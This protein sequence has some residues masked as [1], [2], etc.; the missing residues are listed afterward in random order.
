MT[1][2]VASTPG[3]MF[4]AKNDRTL[5]YRVWTGSAWNAEQS[6]ST[7]GSAAGDNIRHIRAERSDDG[8]RIAIF[9]KTWDGTNQEWWG[10]VYRVAADDFVN[11]EILGASYASADNN[12]LITG[13]IGA[14]S[15]GEF[16]VIRNNNGSAGTLAFSWD[17]TGG[18][19][20]EGSGPGSTVGEVDVMNG[21]QLARREGADNLLLVTFD[22]TDHG[23]NTYGDVGTSYYYGGHA[24]NN[25][26]W[27]AWTEHS[28]E[29]E[30]I[31][32]YLGEAFFDP[33]DNTRGAINYSNSN[34][35]ADTKVK[36][37]T[38]SASSPY[39]SYGAEATTPAS[40][41]GD[42]V[43]GEFSA[44]PNGVGEAWFVGDDING[45]LNIY[46]VDISASTP[47]WSSST[48]GDNI[49]GTGLY[50]Y[51]NDSQK[52][53]A[54]K[55]Y[56]DGY[57]TV[58]WNEAISATPKYRVITASSNTVDAA[59]T[60]VP[61]SAANIWTRTRFYKDP[62]ENEFLAVYQNDD[63]DYSAIFWDGANDEFY[64]S[65]SQE[66]ME[67]ATSTGAT[68]ADYE[69]TAFAFSAGN[70][71][72]NT[73]TDLI[74]YK[75]DVGTVIANGDWI[76]ENT[77]KLVAS[78]KDADTSEVLYVYLQLIPDNET[79]TSTTTHPFN[80]CDANMSFT[81]CNSNIWLVAT[82]SGDYS[83]DSFIA[84]AT[85]TAISDSD[86]G[87]K[88]QV[89]ACDDDSACSGWAK[90][91]LSQ[92]NFYVDIIDPTAPGALIPVSKTS[93]SIDLNFGATTTED[94]FKE[95]K[96]F[97]SDSLPITESSSEYDD[98]VLDDIDYGASGVSVPF[99]APDTLYYFNIFVFDQA[100]NAASSTVVS[101]TTNTTYN[102]VQ[103]SYLLENDDG[104]DVNSNT[105]ETTADV[106]LDDINIGERM[107]VRIQI[108]N[109][110]GDIASAKVYSLQYENYTDASSTWINVGAATEISH[111]PGLSGDNGDDILPPKKAA[112]NLNVWEDG[113]WHK[114]TY[115][116]GSFSLINNY[117]TEFVFAVETSNALLDKTYRLRLYNE[118]DNKIFDGY[119]STS[120]FTTVAVE[121][122]RY[123]KE[124]TDSLLT[125]TDD[126]EYY[127][128][129]E[130]Y[131]DVSSND[132]SNYDKLGTTTAKYA[133][134]NFA[135]KHTNNTDAITVN[136]NGQ[137]DVSPAY[138]AVYLQV[139]QYGSVD[140]WVTV[141]SNSAAATGTDFTINANLNSSLSE[142]YGASNWTY[143][144]VYQD[145]GDQNLKSDYFNASFAAPVPETAQIHYRW[146]NDDGS[147]TAAD[148]LEA[149][150]IGSPTASSSVEIGDNVRLRVEVA[151][152]GG[153]D[154]ANYNYRLEYATTTGNCSTDP[155][156]WL[157]V[158]IDS[159]EHW[160]MATSSYFTDGDP[161]T[162]QFNNT[163]SYSFVAGDMVASSSNSSGNTTL[164]EGEYT[165]IEYVI[166]ATINA[167]SAG[168]YC[169][170]T[171]NAGT[172]LDAYDI[173]P[174]ITLSG[175]SNT[176][177]SFTLTGEP[178]DNNSASSS[179]KHYGSP[180]VF[181]ATAEDSEGDDYYLAICKTDSISAGNDAPPIC[182]G[183]EWC[184]S[185]LASSTDPA[186]CSY[187]AAT[188]T[189]SL[190][191]YGFVCDRYPGFAVGKCSAS[192]QGSNTP[193]NNSPF[194]INHPPIF[195]SISTTDDNKNPG[196]TFT[197][198]AIASDS[199][200]A[201]GADTLQLYVCYTDDASSGGCT[202]G[203]GDTVCS[204]ASS[205]PNV[206]CAYTDTAPTVS[207][208]TAYYAFVFD[209][210][211]SD[212]GHNL[213]A[214]NNS[215]SD[216]YTI[217]NVAPQLGNLVLNNGGDITLDIK[218]AT[219]T[220]QIVN[221]SVDDQ[222]GCSTIQSA[223]G[224]VYMSNV[225]G[226]YNCTAN[227]NDCYHATIN[228]C[229]K[230]CASD[231]TA[232]ITCS[233]AME[234]FAISTADDVVNNPNESYDWRSYM[235]VYDGA[236]YPFATSTGVEVKTT[237]AFE[238][239]EDEIDFGTGMFGGGNTGSNNSTTTI[240]NC[241]NSP[242]NT[243]IKGTDLAGSGEP[244][245]VTKIK[246][247]L[248]NFV[249]TAGGQALTTSGYPVDLI[250]PRATSSSGSEDIIWWGIGIPTGAN[251]EVY[252]GKNTFDLRLDNDDW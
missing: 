221:T 186:T 102:L 117:Y 4:Y 213:A 23:G 239:L 166:K 122:K 217:N 108:E 1:N 136:W 84:T 33:S 208:S 141:D 66:W 223:V 158:P 190:E 9:V 218:S 144:R 78:S 153:G 55:F 95:Y 192:S 150:D 226:G 134:I 93:T 147:E 19:T 67:L 69:L 47:A 116:T 178:I 214:D 231:T 3:A 200:V 234:Y 140:S 211:D 100:G 114:D 38:V 50:I 119:N 243:D 126:L 165:E 103:T 188:S 163:E 73:P 27:T 90:Y 110:G 57:G 241:G 133:V 169:F 164:S 206:E 162:F 53:Y 99:L 18:W 160:Q 138:S 252:T 168:T 54:I 220:V 159:S 97:Y 195:T 156:G 22:D 197:I 79:F 104:A 130:G 88:W 24:Y 115:Q 65:G 155:G 89:M 177:P 125:T 187:I 105:S 11:S 142:Y 225:S 106:A 40:W 245:V 196:G 247:S 137:S 179:P 248:D 13:C 238:V 229:V 62:N 193:A 235:Q 75:S 76:D 244:I 191:W 15:D 132:D 219:T 44:D 128:D 242:I 250:A 202:G 91:N 36:K 56:K 29:E 58:A 199:D 64:G 240:V 210:H 61:G 86:V 230:N 236:H 170:R 228:D 237:L 251:A 113:T 45:E 157:T 233:V 16:V 82:S 185:E 222:N 63:I 175:V 98:A 30:D 101:T 135:A 2:A 109:N 215:L 205:S 37:F 42:F 189:E 123:S 154:A 92:P 41:S 60:A 182:N 107:N 152:T 176:S 26:S 232:E 180:I 249:Y 198:T 246:W 174:V 131:D 7:L 71:T 111:S 25:S 181:D 20:S 52:P 148:W 212:S 6:G 227:D 183:G 31:D 46:K 204:A 87:Y 5:Y 207:G 43:H 77:V 8:A 14:L 21:C 161:T 34:S 118:T 32:N 80:S 171:T 94:N 68:G 194:V 48:N 203:S 96:I 151:N 216:T 127:F 74:Q 112:D 83:A 17:A 39:I 173:F 70:A 209:K 145:I 184:V 167:Q 124:E 59:D 129:G 201:G 121:T 72:P 143:W 49:S 139:Y 85:I 12:Q 172:A 35:T 149:E 120:T 81:D 10:T 146:R 51:T 28:S 224:R